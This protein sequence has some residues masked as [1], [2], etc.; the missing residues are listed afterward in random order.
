MWPPTSEPDDGS[1]NSSAGYIHDPLDIHALSVL[2]DRQL[3]ERAT[4][5]AALQRERTKRS[6]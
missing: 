5:R 6:K 2:S 4:W 3:T 1:M